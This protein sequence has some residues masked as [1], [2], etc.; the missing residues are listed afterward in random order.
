MAE[1]TDLEWCEQ[2]AKLLAQEN[3]DLRAA[4][5]KIIELDRWNN[6]PYGGE[7]AWTYGGCAQIARAAIGE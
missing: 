4:L 5:Q 2:R 6:K 7:D 3:I 1:I